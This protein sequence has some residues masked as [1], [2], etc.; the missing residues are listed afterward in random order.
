MLSARTGDD[1]HRKEAVGAILE[2]YWKPVYCYLRRKGHDNEAAKDITQ[3][4]FCDVVLSRNLVPQADPTKG[5]FRTFLLTALDRYVIDRHRK[6][7]AQVRRPVR[8]LVSLAGIEGGDLPEPSQDATP[9]QA[10]HRAWAS[11]LLADVLDEVARYYDQTSQSAYWAI[12]DARCLQPILEGR[13]PVQFADLCGKYGMAERV[14]RNALVTV[15]RRLARTLRRE[16][17]ELTG[18]DEDVDQ[19]IRDVMEI[20]S[21]PGAA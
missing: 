20:L 5:R 7:A 9:E 17:R 13:P 12:F 1:V 4:F 21:G 3:G 16:V 2:R 8:G 18:S 15:K 6:D 10:F 11:H 14:A 19:E